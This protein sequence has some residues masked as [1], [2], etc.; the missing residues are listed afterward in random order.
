MTTT[1]YAVEH[2]RHYADLYGTQLMCWGSWEENGYHDSDFFEAYWSVEKGVIFRVEVGSTR[3]AGGTCPLDTIPWTEA[4]LERARAYLAGKIFDS[5]KEGELID[6]LT[7]ANVVKGQ[8]VRLLEKHKNQAFDAIICNKCKGTGKW[9]NPHNPSDTRTCFACQGTTVIKGSKQKGNW[10]H[11]EAGLA[12]EAVEDAKAFGRFYDKG[13][14]KPCRENRS[15]LVKLDDG[16]FVKCPVKKLRLDKEPMS[17]TELMERANALSYGMECKSL[18]TRHGG[19]W[20]MNY[21]SILM[22]SIKGQQCKSSP[23][24]ANGPM[25]TT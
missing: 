15:V 24:N 19:W 3:Y 6:V 4:E 20:D 13:Y 12:G 22:A 8:R 14:N 2:K 25:V 10:V 5:I 21:A 1:D 9:V 18:L 16:R 7:P 23:D 17:D 11:Y